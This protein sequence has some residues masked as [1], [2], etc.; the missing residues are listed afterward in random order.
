M[1]RESNILKNLSNCAC[2]IFLCFVTYP[3]HLVALQVCHQQLFREFGHF[4]LCLLEKIL[5]MVLLYTQGSL[6]DICNFFKK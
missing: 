1:Y 5:Y 6:L 4:P 2:K 3:F